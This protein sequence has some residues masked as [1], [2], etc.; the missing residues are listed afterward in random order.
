MNSWLTKIVFTLLGM[1][2]GAGVTHVL[3]LQQALALA[4][5]VALYHTDQHAD[6]VLQAAAARLL[7]A[8]EQVRLMNER[9]ALAQLHYVAE[10]HASGRKSHAD[11]P[12]AQ[13][14]ALLRQVF[15]LQAAEDFS[16]LAQLSGDPHF[17]GP[18]KNLHRQQ[19]QQFLL[20]FWSASEPLLR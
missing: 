9:V 1:G 18:R 10:R 13:H 15:A 12:F 5:E 8:P 17:D 4:D 2:I 19:A 7:A 11:L 20:A 3:G 6:Q 14:C 16:N